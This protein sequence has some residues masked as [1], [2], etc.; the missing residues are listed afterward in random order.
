MSAEISPC[1]FTSLLIDLLIALVRLPD[2]LHKNNQLLIVKYLVPVSESSQPASSH[3][4]WYDGALQSILNGHSRLLSGN[5][6]ILILKSDWFCHLGNGRGSGE[7]P[8]LDYIAGRNKKIFQSR[9]IIFFS[10]VN[11][12]HFSELLNMFL[13]LSQR[14]HE[15]FLL[16]TCHWM[17]ARP[18]VFK[19]GLSLQISRMTGLA[20]KPCEKRQNWKG[21]KQRSVVEGKGLIDRIILH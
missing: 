10:E 12:Q 15:A 20:R 1:L 21:K 16:C 19:K 13:S 5:A 4:I 9:H 3:F 8:S 11:V 6:A 18:S 2:F 14:L 17:M 7:D